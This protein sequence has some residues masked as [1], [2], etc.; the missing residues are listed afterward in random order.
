MDESLAAFGLVLDAEPQQNEP[1]RVYAFNWPTLTL[2]WSTWN[3][4]RKLV[5]KNTVVRDSMDWASVESAMNL[6]GIKRAQRPAIFEGL[7]AMETTAL[8]VLNGDS[9]E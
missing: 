8:K 5:I 4:W 7:R 6:S 9:D 2:F 3:Q 1:F